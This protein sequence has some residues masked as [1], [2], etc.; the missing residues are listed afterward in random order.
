MVRNT[1]QSLNNEPNEQTKLF[2]R[3]LWH[4]NEFYFFHQFYR[5]YFLRE[6]AFLVKQIRQSSPWK[7]GYYNV[8]EVVLF[9]VTITETEQ[10]VTSTV[11]HSER[12]AGEWIILNYICN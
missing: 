8:I 12:Q 1:L 4:V 3:I 11:Q 9:Y 2:F 6:V 7:R 5:N 10:N